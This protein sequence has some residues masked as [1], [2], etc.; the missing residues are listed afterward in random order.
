MNESGA[1]RGLRLR[2]TPLL[3]VGYPQ[4]VVRLDERRVELQGLPEAH[5]GGID[6]APAQFHA[7][8]GVL[9]GGSANRLLHPVDRLDLRCGGS[10][11][12]L[13][14]RGVRASRQRDERAGADDEPLLL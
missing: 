13:V 8:D 5:D 9:T 7:P 1:E 14:Q 2:I 12:R 3:P 4:P 6:P 10:R 11:I